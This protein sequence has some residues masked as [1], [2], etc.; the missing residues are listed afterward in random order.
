MYCRNSKNWGRV[1]YCPCTFLSIGKR[2]QLFSFLSFHSNPLMIKLIGFLAKTLC[3]LK[4]DWTKQFYC[5]TFQSQTIKYR[6]VTI[7]FIV[8]LLTIFWKWLRLNVWAYPPWLTKVLLFHL[9]WL[10]G[11]GNQCLKYGRLMIRDV[12]DLDFA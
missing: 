6:K 12:F 8:I 9:H 1:L 4:S 3:F 7:F 11:F 2:C 10:V 5:H